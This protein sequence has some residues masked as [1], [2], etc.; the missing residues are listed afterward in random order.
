MRQ[1]QLFDQLSESFGR[2][3]TK[4]ELWILVSSNSEWVKTENYFVSLL[5]DRIKR[6]RIIQAGNRYTVNLSIA[7]SNHTRSA[8][9]SRLSRNQR[10]INAGYTIEAPIS[11]PKPLSN[12]G[13]S[14]IIDRLHV[15]MHNGLVE[16]S[17]T[18]ANIV[19]RSI[20]SGLYRGRF[21]LAK[22]Y[23]PNAENTFRSL[24]PNVFTARANLKRVIEQIDKDNGTRDITKPEHAV[25]TFTD[26]ILDPVNDF[27]TKLDGTPTEICELVD[28]LNAA[29][30]Y[31]NAKSLASKVCKY[32]HE[33]EYGHDKFFI[34]DK[35]VR[36]I[37]PYYLDAYGI[38]L[39]GLTKASDFDSL[40][41][42][43]LYGLLNSVYSHARGITK[44]EFDHILWY[45]YR[46][47]EI[48]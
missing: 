18:N 41:Y 48:K 12:S 11:Y 34:N 8:S 39:P 38:A 3:F 47:F 32:L 27:L 36:S 1:S 45:C 19:E 21:A 30:S 28:H 46:L 40:S 13:H 42:T 4:D 17:R 31:Y 23:L 10:A 44:S 35:V 15:H 29:H 37:L 22:K 16:L 9:S 6:G 20:P 26:Y 7:I 5:K 14:A 25:D 24:S 43:Q 33:W 2:A